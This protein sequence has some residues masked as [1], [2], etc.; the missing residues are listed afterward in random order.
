M[1]IYE[2]ICLSCEERFDELMPFSAADPACPS[3][4]AARVRRQPSL[5]GGLTGTASS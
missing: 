1:P 5:I 3:C 2:F 4:G